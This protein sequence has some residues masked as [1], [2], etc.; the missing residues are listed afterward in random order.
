M[1][2]VSVVA[3]GARQFLLFIAQMPD[4]LT[5]DEGAGSSELEVSGVFSSW[6]TSDRRPFLVS[7]SRRSPVTSA[8][9]TSPL[10][11]N[12]TPDRT[13]AKNRGVPAGF[14]GQEEPSGPVARP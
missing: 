6:Q 4:S 5:R 2:P 1:K 14:A 8:S 7:S 12:R 9:T 13:L 3:R 10:W 11:A